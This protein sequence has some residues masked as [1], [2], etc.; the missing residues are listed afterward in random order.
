MDTLIVFDTYLLDYW[1]SH[2]TIFITV[3]ESIRRMQITFAELTC[4][5]SILRF[6]VAT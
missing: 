1:H 2:T 4:G 6:P 3:T 5:I